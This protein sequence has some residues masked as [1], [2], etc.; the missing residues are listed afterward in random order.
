MK[1]TANEPLN[2]SN[3]LSR[4]LTTL[5][6][7]EPGRVINDIVDLAI[8]IGDEQCD[9]HLVANPHLE[10]FRTQL[11]DTYHQYIVDMENVEIGRLLSSEERNPQTFPD[12]AGDAALMAYDRVNDIFEEVDFN[13]CKQFV[14]V[15]C[16]QLPITAIHVM[17]ETKV[18]EI[19]CLDISEQAIAVVERLKQKFGWSR[20]HPMVFDGKHFDFGNADIVYIANMVSPKYQVLNRVIETASKD[21]KLILRE[22]YSFGQL[23]A[24]KAESH[25]GSRFE[26]THRGRG[27]RYLSRDVFIKALD[28]TDLSSQNP[29]KK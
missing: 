19:Y 15:G 23:W 27:S 20:L 8:A 25:F 17:D 7:R 28:A 13:D 12:I 22:P 6:Q 24:E 3:T 18:S 29:C 2:P 16:G 26:V 5:D 9:Q 4:L 14:L 11:T 21:V 10:E 1:Q